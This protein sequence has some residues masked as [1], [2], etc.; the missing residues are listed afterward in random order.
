MGATASVKRSSSSPEVCEMTS[1]AVDTPTVLPT[2]S[3][4]AL[5]EVLRSLQLSPDL[6][7]K[8]TAA[9]YAHV[10]DPIEHPVDKELAR[11]CT[12]DY[13]R[14]ALHA[15]CLYL[16]SVS[17]ETDGDGR[18]D[19]KSSFG[20]VDKPTPSAGAGG[21]GINNSG[22]SKAGQG[23][24]SSA[25]TDSVSGK[26]SNFWS[27]MRRTRSMPSAGVM[28][29]TEGE[30]EDGDH[31]PNNQDPPSDAGARPKLNVRVAGA[32]KSASPRRANNLFAGLGL[33]S[34]SGRAAGEVATPRRAPVRTGHWKLGHEI[35]K[36]SFGAV[37]IGLNEDTGVSQAGKGVCIHAL[38]HR[39]WF[40]GCF[41]IPFGN[42]LLLP[43]QWT[44]LW[45]CVQQSRCALATFCFV[46]TSVERVR[47]WRRPRQQ[48]RR[49]SD[50]GHYCFW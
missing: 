27:R 21:A 45:L 14:G 41:W 31:V 8:S 38:E 11:L 44:H 10:R 36:G 23:D 30:G 22:S 16:V 47:K 37:H 15:L 1:K 18:N 26:L 32:S 40:V 17:S 19:R 6:I 34:P 9:I 20:A 13:T 2:A 29:P 3:D 28:I 42:C 12:S 39:C 48:R 33:G 7:D 25:L 49:P 35:G 24:S 43:S 50:D 5:R 4:A 46:H